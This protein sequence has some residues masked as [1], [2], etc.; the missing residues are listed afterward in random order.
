MVVLIRSPGGLANQRWFECWVRHGAEDA[1]CKE[2]NIF[3]G[4]SSVFTGSSSGRATFTIPG[5]YSGK[6]YFFLKKTRTESNYL[7]VIAVR[8]VP[9]FHYS[10]I[11]MTQTLIDNTLLA[12]S[13]VTA[14][15]LVLLGSKRRTAIVPAVLLLYSPFVVFLN[16]WAHNVAVLVAS[17][18]RY[19]AGVFVYDFR[20]Y[21]LLLFGA[22]FIVV[23]GLNFNYARKIINGD[24][25]HKKIIH[26]LNG[27]TTLFFLPLFTLNPIALLPVIASVISSITLTVMKSG[28]EELTSGPATPSLEIM[29]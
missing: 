23:S 15:L 24:S 4:R 5:T 22:V 10:K 3:L 11:H 25:S 19:L 26:W 27:L 21:S 8:A 14:I 6:T 29:K 17:Y 28:K 9:Q 20:F 13:L 2:Y 16:M 18:N 12:L 7:A 1:C